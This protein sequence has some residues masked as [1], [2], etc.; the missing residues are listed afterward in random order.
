MKLW[1]YIKENMLCH[2]DQIV[3]EGNAELSFE[4]LAVWA[5][6]FSKRLEG[7]KSCAILCKSEMAAAMALL[8]CFAAD[9]TAI[10]LS[11]RYGAIHCNKII[12]TVNPEAVITDEEDDFLIRK[13]LDSKY[14]TP[15]TRPAL[16]MCTSGTTGRPKGAMLSEENIIS[17]VSDIASYFGIGTTDSILISR[18]LYHSAVLTGEFLVSLIKGTK[19]RFY[20]EKFNP[21]EILKMIHEHKITA[22]CG[23]PTLLEMMSAY[24]RN[25]MAETLKYICA[26]GECM[27]RD[28]GLRL[29]D[30]F[31]G[32]KIYHIYGLTE[33]SPRVLYLPPE[34]FSEFPEYVGIPLKSVSVKIA[35]KNGN[36]VLNGKEGVL[37]VRGPN[38]MVGY[39]NDDEKTKAV[40][41]DGWL[42]T[43]DIALMNDSGL[44]RIKGRSDDMII[45]SGMNIYPAEIEAA[46]KNDPRVK[47]V[48]AYGIKTERTMKIGMKICGDFSS[49]KEVKQMCLKYLPA[50]QVPDCIEI[51][52]ELPK[53]G[54]GKIIRSA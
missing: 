18:P 3:C 53:N 52:E 25:N 33:A 23:T 48:F 30:A 35:D 28:T 9:V 21:P 39:Y 2:Y 46:L 10:P 29:K 22:F 15:V 36:P 42:C 31:K 24:N 38:V 1:N 20:S 37:W 16:I 6:L 50:F 45:K 40:L 54:S 7:I 32:S 4:E 44:I 27:S 47:E 11:M 49:V 8:G 43:G 12:E 5:E 41:K 17:N 51:V 13:I 19:I 14:K 26:S 34:K